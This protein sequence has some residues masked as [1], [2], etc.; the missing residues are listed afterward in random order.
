LANGMSSRGCP[1]RRAGV[2]GPGQS[3]NRVLLRTQLVAQGAVCDD[4]DVDA[5]Q[6]ADHS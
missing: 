5:G 1:G 3:L 2:F 6:L 4:A